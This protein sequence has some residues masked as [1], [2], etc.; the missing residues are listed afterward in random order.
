VIRT[1]R[2]WDIRIDESIF[3]GGL[4]KG[5]FLRAY[6]ADVFF[7]DQKTHCES[8]SQHVATGHVPHGIAN[9]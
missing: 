3:L 2:A 7:D 4:D 5:E 6:Q 9:Q 1:L 8:T